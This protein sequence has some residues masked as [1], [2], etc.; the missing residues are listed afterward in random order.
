MISNKLLT[1]CLFLLSIPLFSF[2]QVQD[3]LSARN[4]KKISISSFA[5][6]AVFIGYGIVSLSGDNAIRRLDYTTN[7]ELREDHPT[8]VLKIDNITR[9]TPAVAVYGLDLL[10]VKAKHNVIDRSVMLLMSAVIAQASVNGIKSLSHRMRPNGS[11]SNSF[12]SGHTSFAFMSAEFLNQEYKDQSVW[13]G[14]GG[15]AIATGTGILRLYNNAHWV[16]DVVA[17]A[18][19]GILSTKLTYLVY[20]YIKQKLFRG[21]PANMVF[22]PSFQNGNMSFSLI[23]R[24]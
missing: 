2:T 18:G 17:G 24:L 20:P 3:S 14:I 10:G 6:P 15:Y 16:S 4:M 7:N 23:K 1:T 11:A 12:P 19:F 13:Y 9:Y 21:K 5:V 8:F 22:N